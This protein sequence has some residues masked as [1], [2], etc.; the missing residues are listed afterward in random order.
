MLLYTPTI[1]PRL[2][3][4]SGFIAKEIAGERMRLTD[5]IEVFKNFSGV[6][7]NY[8]QQRVIPDELWIKPHT[9]LFEKNIYP[10]ALKCMEVNRNKAFFITDGDYPF[11]IFAASFYLLS[12]YEEYLPHQ[13]DMYDRYA[14]ENSLAFKQGFLNLPLVN[15]WLG[16]FRKTLREKYAMFNAQNSVFRF[17]PTYDIDEAYSYKYKGVLRTAGAIVKAVLKGRWEKLSERK[18]VIR[19]LMAD[20]FDSFEWMDQL[21]EKYKLK[22]R[23]FFLVSSKTGKYDRNILPAE[24]ALQQLIKRHAAKYE[25]GIHPSWQSGD[26]TSLMN[27][28]IK[29]LGNITGKKITSSRQH[30]IRFTLP[31]TFRILI[32]AGIQEDFSMGYGSINGFRASVA[33]PF[34]WYDLEKEETTSLQL[35]PF[36]FMEANSFFEQK[37]SSQQALE[38]VRYYYKQVKMVNGTMITLWHNTFLGTDKLFTGWREVYEQFIN[39]VTA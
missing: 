34:Y 17:I 24:P 32:N 29:I 7:I 1:T 28:E 23:Y 25:T 8:S 33:S 26:D 4:I 14:H 6:K 5:D 19:G 13:K 3:Y 2:E 39:E 22:S 30:F 9:L 35:Y 27:K 11:D 15:I 10:Q 20:P 16:E 37:Y 31:Q 38:E 12:R 36:C 21:H 18:K